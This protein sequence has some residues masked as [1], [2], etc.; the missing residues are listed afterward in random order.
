ME[1]RAYIKEP[2]MKSFMPGKEVG[3]G[4][5]DAG[6]VAGTFCFITYKEEDKDGRRCIEKS[7]LFKIDLNN[8]PQ[9]IDLEGEFSTYSFERTYDITVSF[10]LSLS[11]TWV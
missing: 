6:Q 7:Q 4:F 3:A 1:S 2:S 9:C 11:K 10:S 5:A 8:A